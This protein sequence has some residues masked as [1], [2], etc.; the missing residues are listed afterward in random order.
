MDDRILSSESSGE[1]FDQELSLRPQSLR[2]YIGQDKVKKNLQVF[3]EAAKMR[4]E[5]LDHV[6]LYGP[7]GLG[8]TTLA[9]I[10]AN[11]LGVG[12]K[13]T[14]GPAIERPGDL[15]AILTSLQPGDVLFIDEI[16]RLPRT[17]EEVLY[18]AMEDFFF[19]IVIG[20]DATARS[21][22]IDL[23]PFTL[24]GATTRAGL[25]SSPLRDRFGVLNRLEF[26]TVEQLALIVKRTAE[27]F[28]MEIENDA[29]L[30][31]ARRS[32][33]TPRIA[34]R[35]L[36]RVRDFAQVQ[37]SEIITFA[38]AK[39]SLIQMQVDEAGL[40]HIDH[41]LLLAIIERFKG[42]PVGVDTIAASIGEESQTI[43]DV[44][45]PYLLQIG[46]LQRTP[47]GRIVT[48]LTYKHF[49]LQ[50]PEQ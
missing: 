9:A 50:V 15:A 43:E 40:D 17:V 23:P 2:E 3:I 28:G 33:G 7:P 29:A 45:E 26:Y 16:H 47:R 10:I 13:T 49:G 35:L 36:R 12:F 4:N 8:K 48:D 5:S 41:K 18:P 32:R 11:E 37:G 24:I 20:K 25:L 31:V 30:E 1:E 39:D 46:F 38:I 14:S 6:L 22:R 21:V 42:G 19:D 34:N 27:L 44:Y